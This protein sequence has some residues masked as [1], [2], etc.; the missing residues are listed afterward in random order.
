MICVSNSTS[1]R[2]NAFQ[3]L[4]LQWS[5]IHPYNAAHVYRIARPMAPEM[6]A[7]AIHEMYRATGLGIAEIGA[8]GLTYRYETDH[9]PEVDVVDGGGN[10]E[11]RLA[12]HLTRELNRPFERPRCKP[13]RFSIL[14]SAADSHYVIAAYDHWTADSSAARLVMQHV[15]DRYCEWNVPE[16]RQPLDLYPG[17]YREVF[18]HRFRGAR[19]LGAGVHSLRQWIGNRSVARVPYSSSLQMDVRFELYRAATGTI[20][21][22]LHY[23]RSLGVTVHDVILAA[24]GRA[25][26]EF[27]PRRAVRQRQTI[28]LGTIVDSRSESK[29][30]LSASLGAFLASYLTRLAADRDMSLADAARCVAA[31]TGPIKARQSYLN[32]MV[33]F[34]LAAA[35]WPRLRDSAKPHFMR[36]TFPMTAGVSNVVVRDDWMTRPQNG[37]VVEYLRGVSTGPILPLV[38]TP[39]TLEGE[40]NVGVTYRIAG[41]SRQKI[42]GLMAMF[43]EQLERPERLPYGSGVRSR[44]KKS[45]AP[46]HVA[47]KPEMVAVG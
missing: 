44:S 16:N 15:L 32:S 45:I 41:F 13:W 10:S 25:M 31:T 34:K 4:M 30:D 23:A 5:E 21:Q 27:L 22:L 28:S 7:E 12:E 42:D 37:R 17:T 1:G 2:L 43:M 18:A 6:L 19:L 35:V 38:L 36:R 14:K 39:T 9:L 33:N 47:T 8:D 11:L 3:R 24:L 26:A 40:L 20:P 46:S 29:E